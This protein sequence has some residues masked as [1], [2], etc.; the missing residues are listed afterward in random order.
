MLAARIGVALLLMCLTV[1]R[2]AT[3]E[4]T[5]GLKEIAD[6]N[7]PVQELYVPRCRL[8]VSAAELVRQLRI[9]AGVVLA[10]LPRVVATRNQI[11]DLRYEMPEL[12]PWIVDAFVFPKGT[13]REALNAYCALVPGLWWYLDHTGVFRLTDSSSA[14]QPATAE[15]AYPL[16]MKIGPLRFRSEPIEAVLAR[17]GKLLDPQA[18]ALGINFHL[19][20]STECPALGC[21][22]LPGRL[23]VRGRRISLRFPGG[24]L[25]QFLCAIVASLNATEPKGAGVFS[26]AYGRTQETDDA[27]AAIVA[28]AE[29]RDGR[30]LTQLLEVLLPSKKKSGANTTLHAQ[31]SWELGLIGTRG[32]CDGYLLYVFKRA[33]LF[34]EIRRRHRFHPKEV[35][36]AIKEDGFILKI[37]K[38]E[39]YDSLLFLLSLES[40][41]LS[42]TIADDLL[43][44]KPEGDEEE[45]FHMLDLVPSPSRFG[46]Q[47]EAIWQKVLNN[48]DLLQRKRAKL[49]LHETKRGDKAG[50]SRGGVPAEDGAEDTEDLWDL[51]MVDGE[52]ILIGKRAGFEEWPAIIQRP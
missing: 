23:P 10:D 35:D 48:P 52:M 39:S 14:R 16:K 30:P 8:W 26:W 42:K 21:K 11:Y 3:A 18:A 17:V 32:E 13:V 45:S 34:W 22:V 1:S 29:G 7:R 33:D 41:V 5:T 2:A 50:L 36:R 12:R 28:L 47:Y 40:P 38:R 37:L 20:P 19:S 46:G 25:E 4:D 27:C 9:P 31:K 6:L 49:I 43:S 51:D 44:F 15:R 24:S